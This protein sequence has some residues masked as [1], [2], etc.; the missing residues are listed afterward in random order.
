MDAPNRRGIAAL[1]GAIADFA[2]SGPSATAL[3]YKDFSGITGLQ[4]NGHA[5]QEGNVLRPTAARKGRAGSVF[6]SEATAL[7]ADVSFS[8]AF[9]LDT[10]SPGGIGDR[11]GRAVPFRIGPSP[12]GW[13]PSRARHTC[14][15]QSRSSVPDFTGGLKKPALVEQAFCSCRSCCEAHRLLGFGVFC[16]GS[17]DFLS[18]RSRNARY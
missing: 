7:A 4:R 2:A 9:R 16:I 15:D 1:T 10:G 13:R 8:S 11:D 14:P 18:L 5:R 6:S 12:G 17:T 3:L